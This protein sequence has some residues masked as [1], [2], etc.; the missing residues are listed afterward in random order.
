M[1]PAPESKMSEPTM[2][3]GGEQHT[4]RVV[5]ECDARGSKL[6]LG[7]TVKFSNPGDVFRP[8]KPADLSAEE[9]AA[10]EAQNW[11]KAIITGVTLKSVSS[12]CPE[13]VTVGLNLFEGQPKIVNSAGWLYAKQTNDMTK[14]HAHQNEG[15]TNLV[16][17]LPNEKQRMNEV[18][19]SPENVLSDQYINKYGA[20]TVEKLWENIVPFPNEPYYYVDQDHVVMKIISQNW[21][22]LGISPENEQ[23]REGHWLKVSKDVVKNCISQLY[24]NVISQIPYTNFKELGAR[25]QG[26]TS[27][28]TRYKVVCEML[29]NYKFP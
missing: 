4:R 27:G 16:T 8:M 24:E 25:F 23:M 19:Y 18:L 2:N 9:D 15:F 6:A 17:V 29:V 13:P 3:A 11:E 12:N 1:E 21:E 10:F 5:F 22:Q 20:Y 26:N 28:D 7:K 14:D